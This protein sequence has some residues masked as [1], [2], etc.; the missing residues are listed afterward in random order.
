MGG[1]IRRYGLRGEITGSPGSARLLLHVMPRRAMANGA[2]HN[3]V[4][5]ERMRYH[6][7]QWVIEIDATKRD[8]GVQ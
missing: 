8:S 2:P 4:T 3:V 6:V 1:A 5:E 7:L